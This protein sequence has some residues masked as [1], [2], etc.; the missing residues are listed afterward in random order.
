MFYNVFITESL[1][2]LKVQ[3]NY[4]AKIEM[5]IIYVCMFLVFVQVKGI[6]YD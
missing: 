5:S 1:F 4:V 2:T 6:C 3:T